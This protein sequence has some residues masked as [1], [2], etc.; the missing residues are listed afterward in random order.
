MG[1]IN[2]KEIIEGCINQLVTKIEIR[3]I[4]KYEVGTEKVS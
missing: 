4:K 2:T 1:R 3:L